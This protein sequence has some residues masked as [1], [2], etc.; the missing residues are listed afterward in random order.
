MVI[1]FFDPVNDKLWIAT[2]TQ[3]MKQVELGDS[4]LLSLIPD[5]DIC[6][7]HDAAVLSKKQFA[8][9][10]DGNFSIVPRT[11]PRPTP[12]AETSP[13]QT[14]NYS[15]Q[16]VP[17][18]DQYNT[19]YGQPITPQIR[20]AS[21][22]ARPYDPNRLYLH[23]AH[24]GSVTIPT[25]SSPMYPDGLTIKG[26]WTFIPVDDIG[27][28]DVLNSNSLLRSLIQKGKIKV[29]KEDYVRKNQHR[30]NPYVSPSERER[31]KILIDEPAQRAVKNNSFFEYGDEEIEDDSGDVI[32][33][34]VKG[35]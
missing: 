3:P 16:M 21:A 4:N 35:D 18:R 28:V 20:A 11:P 29:Q 32:G 1:L 6:Y 24:N 19:T 26:K 33:V 34:L 5:D 15:S 22:N 2:E 14:T 12:T 13:V 17:Q 23:P 30:A 27:G 8:D 7:V 31:Q 10:L 9:M 25:I